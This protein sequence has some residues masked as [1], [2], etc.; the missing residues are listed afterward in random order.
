M[1]LGYE[2]QL[3]RRNLASHPWH[4]GA[5]VGGLALAVVVMIYIPCSMGSFY[6]DII[7]QS[8]EQTS[9][10][11]T[12]WPRE[13]QS[14]Q[15]ITRLK[16]DHPELADAALEDMTFPRKRDLSGQTA[17]TRQVQDV[18]GVIAV[19]PFVKGDATVSRGKVNLGIVIEGIEPRRYARVVNIAKH[20]KNHRLPRLEADD[21]AIGFRMARKLGVREGGRVHVATARGGGEQGLRELRVKA[22]FRSGYYENDMSKAYV[23]LKTGQILFGMGNDVSGLA[24]RC[25]DLNRADE[26]SDRLAGLLPNKVRNWMQDNA[27]LLQEIANIQRITLF[28]S[29]LVAIVASV[30]M[31]N[32]FSMFVLNR[33]KEL[34]ILRAMGAARFSLRGI[35]M[36]EALFIWLLG[37]IL[38]AAGVLGVMAYEQMN[39]MEVSEAT[40]GIEA[41]AARPDLMTMLVGAGLALATMVFSA[42]WSGR[43]ASKMNPAAVIFG[44]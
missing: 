31:A 41:Y 38:G 20:Y 24:A 23:S 42:W 33:Q 13:R 44:R 6:E 1:A 18:R 43:R 14:E 5:M 25:E 27:G 34:A 22:I 4:T 10:H 17:L 26:V 12:I 9:A 36:L 21:V 19:A 28:I 7:D 32:V 15:F 29:T 40:Y 11:I 37:T 2:L 3:A 8:V 35:L 39:P 16:A 30:G